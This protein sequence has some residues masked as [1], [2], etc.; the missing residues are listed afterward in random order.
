MPGNLLQLLIQ[1]EG[2]A[3]NLKTGH[4]VEKIVSGCQHLIQAIRHR[5]TPVLQGFLAGSS[6]SGTKQPPYEPK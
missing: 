5:N 3:G 1:A 2:T 4:Q 6:T